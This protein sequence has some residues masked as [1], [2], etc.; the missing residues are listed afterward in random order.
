MLVTSTISCLAAFN[1]SY[2][3]IAPIIISFN[4]AFSSPKVAGYTSSPPRLL[5]HLPS[6]LFDLQ[7]PQSST[8]IS[9]H[10]LP[11]ALLH[12]IFGR[13]RS[14]CPFTS[15]I[16]AFFSI[17]YVIII[18]SYHMSIPSYSFRFYHSIQRFL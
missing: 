15:S 10:S 7:L 3:N 16:I 1:K 5:S 4:P 11:P 13:P 14:R 17:R 2:A 8:R 6:I 12:I 18:S 9:S